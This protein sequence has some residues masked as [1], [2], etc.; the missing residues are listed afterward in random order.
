MD[1]VLVQGPG[2]MNFFKEKNPD[3][4]YREVTFCQVDIDPPALGSLL[5]YD[6]DVMVHR[7]VVAPVAWRTGSDALHRCLQVLH[8]ACAVESNPDGWKKICPVS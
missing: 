5:E 2:D 6:T 8:N 1:I 7:Y 3:L 4:D